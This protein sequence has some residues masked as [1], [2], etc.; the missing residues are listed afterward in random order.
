MTLLQSKHFITIETLG[1]PQT[2]ATKRKIAKAMTGSK[3]GRWKDG[4]RAYRRIIGAKSGNG[5]LVHHKDGDRTNNKKSN[6]EIV[7]KANRGAHDKAHNRGKNFKKSGGTKSG[8]HTKTSNPKRLRLRGYKKK[9]G[10]INK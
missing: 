8:A 1:R 2:A 10:S 9:R 7:S 3:N 5:N 4:R 6:L